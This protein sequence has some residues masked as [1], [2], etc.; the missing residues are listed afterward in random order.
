MTTKGLDSAF[1]IAEFYKQDL[2]KTYNDNLILQI[3]TMDNNQNMKK[4]QSSPLATAAIETDPPPT[5]ITLAGGPA[6]W[7]DDVVECG[8]P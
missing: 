8:T 4:K 1:T 2:Q 7:G 5:I 6:S 3:C